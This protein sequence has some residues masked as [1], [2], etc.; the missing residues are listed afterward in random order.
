MDTKREPRTLY[1]GFTYEIIAFFG[2]LWTVPDCEVVLDS[3]RIQ[4]EKPCGSNKSQM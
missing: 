2:L 1:P 4:A 3:N